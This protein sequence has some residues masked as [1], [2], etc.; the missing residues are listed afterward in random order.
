[1]VTRGN[2]V[3]V[4]GRIAIIAVLLLMNGFFV[5]VEFALVRSRRTRLE[6]MARAGDGLS[7]LA[8]RAM[9]NIGRLLSAT[10]IGI[11]L[12]SLALGALAEESLAHFFREWL[13]S[14]PA[15]ARIS[16][17]LALGS[18]LAISIVSFFHVVFGELAPKSLAL[19]HPE[20]MARILAPPLMLFEFIMRPVAVVLTKSAQLVLAAFGV[21]GQSMEEGFH[22]P[23]ELLML[24]EQSEE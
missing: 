22:S 10:Q 8:L 2:L 14:W 11:T 7:R 15:I 23:E 19:V 13:G 24:V 18:V 4:L 12:V 20:R 5:G 6:A 16:T 9:D 1:P 17:T 3:A 21:K